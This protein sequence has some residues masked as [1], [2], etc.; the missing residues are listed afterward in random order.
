M[1]RKFLFVSVLAAVALGSF[2]LGRSLPGGAGSGTMGPVTGEREVLYWRAPMDPNFRSDRPGKSPMG[3]DLVPVYADEV[4]TAAGTVAIDPRV[5]SNLG[6]RTEA[7]VQGVLS[8]RIETVGYV[9]FDEETLLQVNTRVEGW[10]ERLA[11]K[12]AGDPVRAG[13][14]LFELYSPTLVNAQQEHLAAMRSTNTLLHQASLERLSAL[15]MTATEIDRL[16]ESQ[17]VEQ[18]IR[19]FAAK[20]GVIAHLD[21]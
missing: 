11:V 3:M 2:L 19:V 9:A 12:A 15:G 13:D 14:V 4:D 1:N 5:L 8:R 7:A 17:S 20:D 6:V 18:R 16:H 10:I 21:D